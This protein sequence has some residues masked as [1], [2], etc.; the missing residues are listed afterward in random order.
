MHLGTRS[1]PAAYVWHEARCLCRRPSGGSRLSGLL[2]RQA[3]TPLTTGAASST[4]SATG[5]GAVSTP[6]ATGH[7]AA[8]ATSDTSVAVVTAE[9]ENEVLELSLRDGRVLRRARVAHDP[10]ALADP[11]G[12]PGARGQSGR[13]CG[14]RAVVAGAAIDRRAQESNLPTHGLHAPAGFED[15]THL[16]QRSRLSG[17]APPSAPSPRFITP[18]PSGRGVGR[19]GSDL[20][21]ARAPSVSL[22]RPC[23]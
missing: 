16:A 19:A 7:K 10:T 5:P 21:A 17:S 9:T 14:H 23:A 22:P 8:G 4:I 1:R 6:P 18:A 2:R 15:G 11:A 20:P 13:W 12:R 3:P